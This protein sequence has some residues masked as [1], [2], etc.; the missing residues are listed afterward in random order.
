MN[1][2]EHKLH[3]LKKFKTNRL[4]HD[5]KSVLRARLTRTISMHPVKER[6]S[7][8]HTT[9]H[10]GLRIALS[11][12]IFVIFVAGSISVVADNA[13]PGDPFYAVKVSIN[14]KVKSVLLQ[15][16]EEKAQYAST[17][18]ATRLNE[19][20][21]LADSKTLTK[22][23]QA[24]VQKALD[25]HLKDISKQLSNTDTATALQVTASLQ[26]N[27]EAKKATLTDS[28]PDNTPDGQAQKDAAL[29]TV[30]SALA[31][32]SDQEVKIISKEVDSITTD[33][34]ATPTPIPSTSLDILENTSTSVLNSSGTS[35]SS[36]TSQ[37]NPHNTQKNTPVTP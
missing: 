20:Q 1:T 16:P 24:V 12:S 17:L 5:E 21:T 31:Q 34:L 3:S 37:K 25:S 15:S 2:M 10:H 8:L 26:Q 22:E 30:N 18:V 32:V 9:L 33:T 29:Q 36:D 7:P 6:L 13:Q 11:T 27:L 28:I 4:S 23:K 14:E 19:I 35:N